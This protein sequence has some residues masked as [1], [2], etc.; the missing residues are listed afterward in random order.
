LKIK[1]TCLLLLLTLLAAGVL[2]RP[3]HKGVWRW[4]KLADGTEVRA[5]L[6]GDEYAHFW[7]TAD[8]ERFTRQDDHYMVADMQK[9]LDQ[10]DARRQRAQMA[11]MK[12]TRK[13]SG[14]RDSQYIGDKR[15]IIILV[16][17]S[18]TQFAA[19]HDS[20][21][22]HRIANEQAF[23][24]DEG[25]KGSVSDYFRDQSLG[26]LRLQFD[27]FGPVRLPNPHKYYGA[28]D[29]NTID[30]N[31]YKMVIEACEAI[32]GQT[33][34][35]AYDWDD[36]GE[37]DQVFLI[38]AGE[39]EAFSGDEDTVWPHECSLFEIQESAHTIG[40]IDINTYACSSE[41]ENGRICGI[42]T[43][44]HEF[45]H[46]LGLMD[47]YD[48]QYTGNYG[49]DTW[50]VM[51]E[52]CDNGSGFTPCCYTSFER[53]QCG[54]MTPV[55]INEETTV[56]AM[57]PLSAGGHAYIL[58][59]EGC[60]QE[61]YLLENRQ[62]SGWDAA[63][64]GSG[65]LIIH[66]DY[67]L[68]VWNSNLVNTTKWPAYNDHQ[69]CT[70]F[71]ASGKQS[72]SGDPYPYQD[73]DSLTNTSVPQATLYNKNSAG[74]RLM[75][76]PITAIRQNP[77]STIS[78]CVEVISVEPT[79]TTGALFYESFDQCTGKGG[80]DNLWSGS[81]ATAK[82][83]PDCEGWSYVK[84][85]GADQCARF[86]S[87]AKAR[88]VSTPAFSIDGK[89]TLSFRAGAWRGDSTELHLSVPEGFTITPSE[90][91]MTQEAWTDFT[92]KI[93]GSGELSVTFTSAGRFFLDEVMAK[94][95][96][97]TTAITAVSQPSDNRVF[98]I[99]GRCLGTCI[100]LL[101]RGIYI[102]GGKKIVK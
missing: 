94:P 2:G 37:V 55:E 102:Q 16:E 70:V 4:L 29:G 91:Q 99:D 76:K 77:D 23:S 14:R 93:I 73:N 32:K 52:G 42:G 11:R 49:M 50:D 18:D 89:A 79:D 34:F 97:T 75:N 66:V 13:V 67:D 28:N 54:W 68:A 15:G 17:F 101:P 24:S 43:I 7:Q 64:E 41:L 1:V 45:S 35:T 33:D 59:A 25:F 58:R 92:V 88:P 31:A 5:Q 85:Y 30:P 78:F 8:G 21:Y 26:Q 51:D 69:R 12:H 65:L 62:L 53:M 81:I 95:R 46:C 22:F 39:G 47:M 44:C 72:P 63:L 20:A 38:Y 57:K 83:R 98:S 82:L 27:I 71:H 74:T 19:G 3:A 48:T 10:A 40:S 87:S 100:D 60:P 56:S 6:R 96:S 80:N 9:I 36:D 84:G 90:V 61:Y 86:N